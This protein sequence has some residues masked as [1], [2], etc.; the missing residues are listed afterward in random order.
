MV[1]ISRAAAKMT[2]FAAACELTSA[3]IWTGAEVWTLS[4]TAVDL[5]GASVSMFANKFTSYSIDSSLIIDMTAKRNDRQ[6]WDFGTR[7]DQETL[8]QMQQ[9]HQTEP[10]IGSAPCI[11]C[12]TILHS[13]EN[14]TKEQIDKTQDEYTQ[15]CIQAYKRQL[16]MG[17]HFLHEH[18]VHASSWRMPEVRELMNDGKVHLVQ[19]PMC[20]WRMTATDDRDEQ[21]IVRGKTRWATS[22]SRLAIAGAMYSLKLVKEVLKALGKQLVDDARLDSVSLYL[23]GPTADFLELDTQEWQEDDYDQQGHLLDPIKFKEGKR[24]EIDWVLKQKFF[25]YVPEN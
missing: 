15:A 25:D 1:M 21:G 22:S 16:S 8:E 11:S 2:N 17:R 12:R 18:P 14:G 4:M 10:L 19:G 24:E 20:R 13:S 23:A 3:E 7:E 9:E 6:F 5:F